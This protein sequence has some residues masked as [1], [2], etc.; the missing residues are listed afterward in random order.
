MSSWVTGNQKNWPG[1]LEGVPKE[2]SSALTEPAF[3]MD[4]ISFCLWR[5]NTDDYWNCGSINYPDEDDPD[6]SEYLFEILNCD[7]KTYQEFAKEYYEVSIPIESVLH[8]YKHLPLTSNII[9]SLNDE[10]ALSDIETELIEIGYPYEDT[11]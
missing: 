1:L 2:L 7:P 11:I 10:I 3:S 6:G 8:I 4:D 9:T 5:L